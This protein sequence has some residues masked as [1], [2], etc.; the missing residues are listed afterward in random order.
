MSIEQEFQNLTNS[1]SALGLDISISTKAHLVELNIS[2]WAGRKTDRK[3]STE[4]NAA[5][6]AEKDT[7]SVRKKL[8][9][10][11][12]E[13]AAIHTFIGQT[14]N[15]Q[16]KPIT[17]PWSDSGIRMLTEAARKR[18]ESAMD[19]TIVNFYA[20]V[21]TFIS[22]YQWKV[23]QAQLKLGDLFDP[24]EYP[25]AESL[26]GKFSMSYHI[27]PLPE[28][29][30][31]RVDCAAEEKDRLQKLH[32]EFTKNQ[33]EAALNDVWKRLYEHLSHLSERLDYGSNEKKKVFKEATLDHVVNMIDVLGMCNVQDDPVMTQLK[34]DLEK[35]MRGITTEALREDDVLRLETKRKLDA[36]IAALPSL[37]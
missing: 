14:R 18:Y 6:N 10:N 35:A 20:L 37:N 23:V 27:A 28:S 33:V 16:H 8:L 1:T 32:V 2:S 7:A 9:G 29:G 13:L 30:D 3:A 36:A 17:M 5:N 4:V 24:S 26:R 22:S 31:F 21:D 15:N 34:D 19:E 11:C 25:S 12:E